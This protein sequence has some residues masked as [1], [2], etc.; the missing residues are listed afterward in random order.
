MIL[1]DSA[2]LRAHTSA[3]LGGH[4]K[5]KNDSLVNSFNDC[6]PVPGAPETVFVT[7]V[8]CEGDSGTQRAV[9]LT[10]KISYGKRADN[11][12]SARGRCTRPRPGRPGL[13]GQQSSLGD[14]TGSSDSSATIVTTRVKCHLPGGLNR[15]LGLR[16]F[17]G[18]GRIG[19]LPLALSTPADSWKENGCW[20]S[21]V[22]STPASWAQGPSVLLQSCV[23]GARWRPLGRERSQ[24]PRVVFPHRAWDRAS[25]TAV[26]DQGPG[27][28][29]RS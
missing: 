11:A 12:T 27:A 25:W 21:T 17:P 16:V 14:V 23:L 8:T 19:T 29:P 2:R 22:L 4:I 26:D 24:A 28:M 1:Q 3:L 15:D 9:I 18:A 20:A 10:V 13:C 5:T 6:G 7:F